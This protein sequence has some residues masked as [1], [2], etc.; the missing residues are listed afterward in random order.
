MTAVVRLEEQRR[1]HAIELIEA[2]DKERRQIARELH[3][4]TAQHLTA[5]GLLSKIMVERRQSEE[6]APLFEELRAVVAQAQSEIRTLSYLLHPPLLDEVGLEV[7]LQ[8]YI[9]GFSKRTGVEVAFHWE[10]APGEALGGDVELAILR[11]AQEAL[12]NVHRHSGARSAAVHVEA[13]AGEVR[14]AI[15]DTGVGIGPAAEEG[16]G[17]P[18]MRSRVTELGGTFSITQDGRGTCLL[19]IFPRDVPDASTGGDV[20]V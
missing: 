13:A 2:Q 8:R 20:S 7:A 11:V 1:T 19:A 18:G 15:R 3:D 10:L 9:E 5:I 17:I 4:T 14:V 6:I 16:L 12:A